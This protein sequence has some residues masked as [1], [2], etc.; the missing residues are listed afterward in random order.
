M[1]IELTDVVKEYISGSRT[2]SILSGVD[3]SIESGASMAIVGPSGSGKTT[4]LGLMA[5]LDSP[6]RGHVLLGQTP[7][8]DLTEDGRAEFRAINVGFV[9]QTFNLLTSL[10][11][12]EN[13]Q[14]PLE[15]APGST[16]LSTSEIR[17]K[18]AELLDRVGLGDRQTH[19]PVQLSGG[20]QQRVSLA[21][22]FVSEP[23]IL[24]ADEPTGNLDRDTGSRIVDLL[25]GLNEDK[26]TTMVLVTHDEE[27]AERADGVVRLVDGRVEK[28][29]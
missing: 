7:L 29:R 9:F 25:R 18:A 27:I 24:F 6:T 22:A 21:R 2:L 3:L 14:V 28:L 15:L 26:G 17:E 5:G 16:R 1:R 12:L 11:A 23:N 10:T 19:Y 13:V 4:L 20:E 8:S